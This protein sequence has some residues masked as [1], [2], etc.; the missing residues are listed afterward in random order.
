MGYVAVWKALEQ[1]VTDFRKKE[2]KVPT[3]I[4][5]DLKNAKTLIKILKAEPTRGEN[6]QKIERCLENV[7]S[8]LISEG[9]REFGIEYADKW[10]ERLDKANKEILDEE[11]KE[12]RFIPG[13]PRHRKWI[14]VTSSADLP[15]EKLTAIADQMN[16][17]Y[18]VHKNGSLLVY[19]E[20]QNIKDFV[21]KMASKYESTAEKYR[22]KVHNR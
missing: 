20:D 5:N 12:T 14:R 15:L 19:G 22:K 1:M 7:E 9:Q 11:D 8:Y 4:M 13:L 17:S 18:N 16:L 3:E 2:L 6:V 21:K 10:L